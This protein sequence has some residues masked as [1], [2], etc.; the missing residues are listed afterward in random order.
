MTDLK[1]FNELLEIQAL[2]KRLKQF[3]WDIKQIETRFD[4]A[5]VDEEL[6]PQILEIYKSKIP[7]LEQILGLIVARKSI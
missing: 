7:E 2:F 3:S 4:I 6:L 5:T 1:I